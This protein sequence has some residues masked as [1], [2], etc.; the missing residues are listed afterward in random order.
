LWKQATQTVFGDG[1]AS[2]LVMLVGEQ[3]GDVK[4]LKESHLSAR[5]A[6][7]LREAMLAAEIDPHDAYLTNVVKH[8]RWVIAGRGQR[9]IHK[10]PRQSEINA[11]H[12]WLEAELEAVTPKVWARRPQK[13]FW[14]VTSA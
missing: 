6:S 2:A 11:C 3:P 1:N 4:T 5:R 13:C 8:F 12:L 7:L 14:E 10:K 9:R